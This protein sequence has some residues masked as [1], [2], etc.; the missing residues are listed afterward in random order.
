MKNKFQGGNT[1][2]KMY[3]KQL[4]ISKLQEEVKFFES[5]KKEIWDLNILTARTYKDL[6]S[7]RKLD[8]ALESVINALRVTIN[9]IKIRWR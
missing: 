8:N 5:E 7:A 1:M 6:I 3:K 2:F 9:D 4:V